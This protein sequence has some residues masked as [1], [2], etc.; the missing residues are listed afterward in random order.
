MNYSLPKTEQKRLTN[1]AHKLQHA[2]ASDLEPH[3]NSLTEDTYR[4]NNGTFESLFY[5]PN[6]HDGQTTELPYLEN[7]SPTEEKRI[8]EFETNT[9][10]TLLSHGV[11]RVALHIDNNPNYIVK[12]GRWGLET[13]MG[14]GVL[15]NH[16]E[17]KF[18]K[19]TRDILNNSPLLP[20]L[21]SDEGHNWLLQ[22]KVTTYE[23]YTDENKPEFD[24]L[25]ENINNRLGPFS[26]LVTNKTPN[27]IGYTNGEWYLFD[28][29]RRI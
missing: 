7:L 15:V 3:T 5:W 20:I 19:H 4:V 6:G 27:N 18:Y 24:T 8:R 22:R 26:S 23:E 2:R 12:V 14:N 11:G 16:N 28:Y 10:Y 25:L 21:Q 13:I 1:F 29:G 17:E 9:Q